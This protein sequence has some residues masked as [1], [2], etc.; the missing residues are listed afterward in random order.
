MKLKRAV[1]RGT[2]NLPKTI[3]KLNEKVDLWLGL[4]TAFVT[5]GVFVWAGEGPGLIATGLAILSTYIYSGDDEVT[6]EST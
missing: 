6:D 1:R 3:A 4:S 2:S 5:S